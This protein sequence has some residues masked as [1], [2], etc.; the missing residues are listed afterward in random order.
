MVGAIGIPAAVGIVY[1]GG[2]TFAAAVVL[3]TV[4]ALREFY[5]LAESKHASPNI[6]LGIGWSITLQGVISWQV[7]QGAG[8]WGAYS[9]AVSAAVLLLFG[10]L[11]TL[12]VE[13][14]RGKENALLN[15]AITVFGVAYITLALSSLLLLRCCV[16]REMDGLWSDGG[17]SLVLALFASVWAADSAAY[18]AGVQFGRHKLLPRVS[19]K[20]SWEGAIAGF[21]ASVA[22]FMWFASTLLP[23]VDLLLAAVCG[24]V[25]GIVG[26]LGDLA[27]S[28][29]KRDAVVKDSGGILP[30]HG[31]V[32]DRFD[33]LLFAAPALL[34]IMFRSAIVSLLTP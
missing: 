27:E 33:S 7:L 32:F 8:G 18:F 15:T 12:A 13:I 2:W 20:K 14:F 19:P 6:G 10:S 26:P 3:L 30:G 4:L 34:V 23:G 29:L 9:A 11:V 22:V 17:A 28:L 24:A 5:M 25:V 31:G 21:V 1:V 16:T